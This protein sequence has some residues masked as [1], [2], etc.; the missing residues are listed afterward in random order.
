M[1]L[2]DPDGEIVGTVGGGGS[3]YEA[4]QRA[5]SVLRDKEPVLFRSDMSNSDAA[6]KGMICGGEVEIWIDYVAASNPV[7]REI[8]ETLETLLKENKQA[9]LGFYPG[10]GESSPDACRECLLQSDGTA[11]GVLSGIAGSIVS[12]KTR[13]QGFDVFT[14]SE[15]RR[16][17]LKRMGSEGKAIVYGAGHVALELVPLLSMVGFETVVIDD[18]EEFANSLRYPTADRVLAL[19]TLT[20]G[21]VSAEPCDGDTYC[22]I[23]TRGH[24]FDRDVLEQVLKTDA[25][26]IGMI[27]SRAKRDAIY[28]YLL[29]KGFTKE[30]L[31]RVYSPI[32]L[33][34]KAQTPEEIAVSIAAE[35]ILARRECR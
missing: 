35:M 30:D 4:R 29:E 34:I 32:G 1:M 12:G 10:E 31:N 20:E 27:G 21:L 28:A 13:Y 16:L 5:A 7:N 15:N 2:V 18:R 17:Y 25:K 24:S 8:Y 6:G 26:Y 33:A 23:L 9:W 22:V 19:A 14:V 3:E 11:I